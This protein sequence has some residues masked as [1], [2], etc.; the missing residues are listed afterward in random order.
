MSLGR[1]IRLWR[2]QVNKALVQFQNNYL[3]NRRVFGH[4][5]QLTLESGNLCN[6]KCPLCATTHREDWIP[7]GLLKYED[8]R[9]IIDRFPYVVHLILSNWGEPF[10]NR[11]LGKIIGYAKSRGIRV[12]M[13]SNLT[14]LTDEQ[15]RELVDSKLDTLAVA[16]DGATQ[17]G[18]E[19]YRVGGKLDDVLRNV[20]R[21]RAMQRETGNFH[22]ELE[23]KMVIHRDNEH[24]VDAARKLAQEF[25]M[26]FHAVTIW[27]PESQQQWLPRSREHMAHRNEAGA[28]ARCHN[29]WQ[30]VSVNFN[31]DVFPCCSEF[32]PDD[33]LVNVLEQP[34]AP[35]WNS[36]EYQE[37]RRLNRGPVDCSHCHKNKQTRWHA[38][39]LGENR[40]ATPATDTANE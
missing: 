2:N 30:S 40:P 37:R 14:R 8:A 4:P 18:Y 1:R 39:W 28:P 21:I 27:A 6:L 10:L 25:G 17:Q 34:F 32:T 23:W 36:A 3:R 22:T 35:V 31:G 5:F 19:K 20:R 26:K 9:T 24:E 16:A 38:L 13:E 12:R 15:C 33:K 11:D 29:L 7:K